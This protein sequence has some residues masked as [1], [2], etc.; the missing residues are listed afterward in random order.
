M[1]TD[2]YEFPKSVLEA[3]WERAKGRCE[4][5]RKTHDHGRRCP[6]KLG[7]VTVVEVVAGVVGKQIILILRRVQHFRTVRFYAGLATAK[8]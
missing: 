6:K 1:S 8:L 7:V 3:A 2:S 4:C 5:R